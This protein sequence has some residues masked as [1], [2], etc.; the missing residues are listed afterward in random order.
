MREEGDSSNTGSPAVARTRGNPR[1]PAWAGGVGCRLVVPEKLGNAGGGKEPQ[2]ERCCKDMETG[3]LI[4]PEAFGHSRRRYMR[5][6]FVGDGMISSESRVREP[7]ARFDERGEETWLWSRTEA[8]AYAKAAGN[9]YSL[10]LTPGALSSTLRAPWKGAVSQ[11]V[12]IPPA[13]VA[14]PEAGAVQG[15]E[16]H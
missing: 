3:R 9:S 16:L 2:F 7:H 15:G 6:P 11:R 12:R 14:R 13:T 5:K 1:G 4:A 8:P 10:H